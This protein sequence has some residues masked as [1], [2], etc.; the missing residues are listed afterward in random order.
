MPNRDRVRSDGQG[1]WHHPIG[2]ASRAALPG[3]DLNLWILWIRLGGGVLHPD[4][5]NWLVVDLPL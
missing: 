2:R 4:S 3:P 1:T 5:Y